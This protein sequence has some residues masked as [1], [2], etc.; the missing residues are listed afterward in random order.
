MDDP[1]DTT[2][3]N[4]HLLHTYQQRKLQLRLLVAFFA[5][6]PRIFWTVVGHFGRFCFIVELVCMGACPE[7]LCKNPV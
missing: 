1:N 7:I 4:L 5:R 2:D 6:A 3:V